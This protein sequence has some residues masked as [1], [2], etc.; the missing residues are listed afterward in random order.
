MTA[1][2]LREPADK[3]A[4]VTVLLGRVEKGGGEEDE[5]KKEKKKKAARQERLTEHAPLDVPQHSH[6]HSILYA[7]QREMKPVV[8]IS[9][10]GMLAKIRKGDA[11]KFLHQ[12]KGKQRLNRENVQK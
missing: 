5:K 2:S 11:L 1:Q 8:Q 9:M 3:N 7:Y 10:A 6:V 12:I 4:N